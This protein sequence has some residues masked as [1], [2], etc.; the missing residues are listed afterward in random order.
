MMAVSILN[1][2]GAEGAEG[3]KNRMRSSQ[4]RPWQ[5]D[6]LYIKNV[7]ISASAAM[8][9][10]AHAKAG[11]DKGLAG[12]NRMPVEVMGFLHVDFDKS[13]PRTLV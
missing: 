8:K 6:P 12:P 3:V 11:V 2:E 1:S 13:D 5:A 10:L 9:M 4:L 7:K